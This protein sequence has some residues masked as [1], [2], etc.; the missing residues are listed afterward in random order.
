MRNDPAA[1]FPLERLMELYGA[2]S[3]STNAVVEAIASSLDTCGG[4]LYLAQSPVVCVTLWRHFAET[5][6]AMDEEE[7]MR[8]YD[9]ENDDA[10]SKSRTPESRDEFLANFGAQHQWWKRVYF[11]KPARLDDVASMAAAHPD[12]L[13][14][15]IYRAAV[16]DRVFPEYSPSTE[17]LRQAVKLP[18]DAVKGIHVRLFKRYACIERIGR[19][20]Q[21]RPTD[22]NAICSFFGAKFDESADLPSTYERFSFP[23]IVTNI[24]RTSLVP[25]M[26]GDPV[27]SRVLPR[28]L[29]VK[30]TQ[31]AKRGLVRIAVDIDA[32]KIDEELSAE[33]Q[34]A[35]ECQSI[36]TKEETLGTLNPESGTTQR[37]KERRL[38]VPVYINLIEEATYCN[39][40]MT[41]RH[42]FQ[43]ILEKLRGTNAV[44]PTLLEVDTARRAFI[45]R[46]TRNL[47]AY[48][49]YGLLVRYEGFVMRHILI[50]ILHG[51]ADFPSS[52]ADDLLVQMKRELPSSHMHF[53]D[54]ELMGRVMP[55]LV[56]A[57]L[58]LR[59]RK[60]FE[61]RNAMRGLCQQVVQITYEDLVEITWEVCTKN[62]LTV[63]MTRDQVCK[64]AYAIIGT[65]YKWVSRAL[66]GRP[67]AELTRL[68]IKRLRDPLQRFLA[69][70]SSKITYF[71]VYVKTWLEEYQHKRAEAGETIDSDD[72]RIQGEP[73]KKD[74]EWAL[75]MVK[76]LRE[77]KRAHIEN[78][79]RQG[80]GEE[81]ESGF[82]YKAA[83]VQNG[84]GENES[85]EDEIA[86]D[87]NRESDKSGGD[88]GYSAGDDDDD[89]DDGG[90]ESGGESTES[91]LT[92]PAKYRVTGVKRKSM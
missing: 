47:L 9:G 54:C 71:R 69:L 78:L 24:E 6:V 70:N 64:M 72:E 17:V 8:A 48:G 52:F 81:A 76:S 65:H 29:I 63:F 5:I 50:E 68:N 22:G 90:G 88:G 15:W 23:K 59:R 66:Q 18:V 73:T 79:R 38:T 12:L 83:A 1:L 45:V 92:L 4:D 87:A 42:L 40:R 51:R 25:M 31:H 91:D 56:K 19:C 32:V 37:Y 14:V 16:A 21:C 58:R 7:L 2:G 27:T 84:D 46:W 43:T 75:M 30:D 10:E 33:L 77:V 35:V 13:D 11:S 85:A 3:V 60:I 41:T 80:A 39:P 55:R 28:S 89:S 44:L 34:R 82:G 53:P 36:R 26:S 57:A 67:D 86:V 74:R 61:V 49:N 62:C 20:V